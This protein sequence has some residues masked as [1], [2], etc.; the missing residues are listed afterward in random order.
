MLLLVFCLLL[1]LL[2]LLRR[3]RV[4]FADVV[5]LVVLPHLLGCV[6]GVG[7][8]CVDGVL[9]AVYRE[10]LCCVFVVRCRRCGGLGN[11]ELWERL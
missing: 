1:L 6:G 10:F 2:L 4:I 5:V 11:A 8:W 7:G 3:R 9:D